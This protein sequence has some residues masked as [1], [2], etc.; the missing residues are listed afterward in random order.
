MKKQL[1]VWCVS[2]AV[3]FVGHSAFA[4]SDPRGDSKAE[5]SKKATIYDDSGTNSIDSIGLSD[6][7]K[8]VENEKEKEK[9]KK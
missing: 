7:K 4:G 2:F 3:L 1:L 6:G 9:R 8:K 5:S